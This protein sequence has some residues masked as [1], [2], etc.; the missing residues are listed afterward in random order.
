MGGGGIGGLQK[1]AKKEEILLCSSEEVTR[2]CINDKINRY[3]LYFLKTNAAGTSEDSNLQYI[4][5]G[6]VSH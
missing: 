3:F 5:S 1:I 2:H 4:I 6:T